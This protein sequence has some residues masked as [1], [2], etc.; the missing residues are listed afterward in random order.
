MRKFNLEG[1]VGRVERLGTNRHQSSPRRSQRSPQLPP[2]PPARTD[3]ELL[4]L[5]LG[6]SSHFAHVHL[7]LAFVSV[8][9]C[10]IHNL[11][12]K[13]HLHLLNPLSF[14]VMDSFAA[15]ILPRDDAAEKLKVRFFIIKTFL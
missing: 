9:R 7:S 5:A 14:K 3:L 4:S 15:V 8:E 2:P 12:F 10:L 1:T 13:P 11:K 6:A